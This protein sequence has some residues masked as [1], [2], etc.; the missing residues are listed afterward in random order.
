[1]KAMARSAKNAMRHAAPTLRDT[2]MTGLS[3]AASPDPLHSSQPAMPP[4]TITP[5]WRIDQGATSITTRAIVAIEARRR[6][7]QSVRAI[8]MT[9]CATM[10]TATSL[11]P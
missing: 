1:M 2:G 10:A 9:A 3:P 4:T 5:S 7:G 11:S 6:S 8:P